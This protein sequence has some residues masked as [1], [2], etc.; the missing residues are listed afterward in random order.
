[1]MRSTSSS[2]LVMTDMLDV[3]S[4]KLRLQEQELELRRGELAIEFAKY[5]FY[6][7]LSAGIC[8]MLMVLSLSIIDAVS[9]DFTFGFYGVI[10]TTLSISI[11]CVAFGAFSLFHSV[12]ILGHFGKIKI[13]VDTSSEKRS[14]DFDQK[15][16]S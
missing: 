6:G 2:D 1:Q 11:P 8:G 16:N 5:G 15:S 9:S 12:R 4:R 3:E 7:T 13:G 10:G 14:G